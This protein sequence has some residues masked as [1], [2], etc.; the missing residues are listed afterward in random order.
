MRIN[1]IA[2]VYLSGLSLAAPNVHAPGATLKRQAVSADQIQRL[3]AELVQT[4]ITLLNTLDNQVANA[5]AVVEQFAGGRNNGNSIAALESQLE[6]A[7]GQI[8]SGADL[9]GQMANTLQDFGSSF[10]GVEG[11]TSGRFD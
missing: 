2:T 9:F 8:A 5:K 4:R 10:Q 1:F 6:Q 11:D 7:R 3:A